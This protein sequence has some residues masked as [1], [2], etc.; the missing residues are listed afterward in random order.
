MTRLERRIR[1]IRYQALKT[2]PGLT[3]SQAVDFAR[4]I[5]DTM[6]NAGAIFEDSTQFVSTSLNVAFTWDADGYAAT[7]T[8]GD[9]S[10]YDDFIDTDVPPIGTPNSAYID[11][12]PWQLLG[13]DDEYFE[14]IAA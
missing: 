11:G 2:W 14:F 9:A 3:E 4:R 5:Y 1:S 12:D 7:M 6:I 13:N 10:V 8:L